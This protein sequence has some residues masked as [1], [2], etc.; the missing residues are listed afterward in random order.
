M[1]TFQLAEDAS[2]NT[3]AFKINSNHEMVSFYKD[4]LGFTLKNEENGLSIFDINKDKKQQLILEET[5]AMDLSE[6]AEA[7]LVHYS[8]QMGSESEFTAALQHFSSQDISTEELSK[9][10]KLNGVRLVDP[11]KNEIEFLYPNKA[12]DGQNG[13]T[14][15]SGLVKISLNTA[16]KEQSQTFYENI[17][18]M[19]KLAEDL[20]TFNNQKVV[21]QLV[22]EK[23]YDNLG[24]SFFVVDLKTSEEIER[25]SEHLKTMKQDFFVDNKRSILTVFDVNGIEWWFVR[26]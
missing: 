6:K 18:G 14:V 10:K 8:V 24:W 3:I 13:E 25:L 22:E 4:V 16:N 9:N 17:F 21:F 12:H 23:D 15:G 1:G 5:D 2:L 26:E 7:S 11:E 19:K 20:L